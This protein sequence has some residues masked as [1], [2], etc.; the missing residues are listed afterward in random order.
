LSKYEITALIGKGGMATVYK[1]YQSEID[2]YVAIKVLPP[3]PGQDEQFIER[4]RLEART[5]A[6]LQHPHILPLYDYGTQDDVLYLVMAYMDGGSLNDRIRKNGALPPVEVERLLGQVASALDY[7][8]RQGIIHRDIKPDNILLDREGFALLADFGIVKIIEAGGSGLTVTGGLMGTPAYM[9][10][11][12]GQGLS[13]D[14]R[15]DIYSLGVVVYEMLT[16]KPPYTADTPMQLVFKQINAPV[17]DIRSVRPDFPERLSEIIRRVL[18]K[19]P[20]DRYDSAGALLSDFKSALN[21]NGFATLLDPAGTGF[22]VGTP[23]TSSTSSTRAPVLTPLLNTPYQPDAAYPS[24][25]PQDIN[26]MSGNGTNPS[27]PPGAMSPLQP[28]ILAQPGWNPLI[29]LVGVVI[30][31][32]LVVILVVILLNFSRPPEQLVVMPPDPST[33]I[34]AQTDGLLTRI[35]TVIAALPAFAP[36][37]GRLSF[38]TTTNLGDTINLRAE[39]LRP[40]DSAHVYVAWLMS[41]EPGIAPLKLGELVVDSLGEGLLSYTTT[42]VRNLATDHFAVVISLETTMNDLMPSGEI[43]YSGMIPPQVPA[44]LSQILSASLSGFNGGSLLDGAITEGRIAR[45]HAGLAAGSTTPG[46]LHTHA[47]H[48]INVLRGTQDDYT[49]DGRGANPG[50]G[51]GVFLFLQEISDELDDAAT[52]PGT[53]AAQQSQIELIRV[54]VDNVRGWA[55]EVIELEIVM[56]T[57]AT[58]EEV[59]LQREQSTALTAAM[60][61]GIDLNE[62]GQVEPFEGECG[63][64]QIA[65]YGIAV[66][67]MEL[68]EGAQPILMEVVSTAVSG[69]GAVAEPT[70]DVPIAPTLDVSSEPTYDP[71][72]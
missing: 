18:A 22:R 9:S 31:G 56:A 39:R 53:N 43:V 12:Q 38:G 24:G 62:N 25:I 49:G 32:L 33:L 40:P 11:E 57:A 61:D 13:I 70:S 6:R 36:S 1:G 27:Y 64:N 46:A 14:Q 59:A 17:P 54:C 42:D 8:H 60:I 55:N 41:T 2:R 10:P 37:Y 65:T 20:N 26:P 7:A 51:I 30:I 3:H 4:F 44:A 52:A 35:P 16:G 21:E 63:L 34:A 29:L 58:L 48:T 15:S 72:E 50:R 66:S 67:N 45:Q 71:G 69:T 19:D 28:T 68:R 5:I 47:E 23:P